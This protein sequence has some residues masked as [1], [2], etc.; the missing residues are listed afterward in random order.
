[1]RRALSR[2]WILPSVFGSYRSP[3]LILLASVI[4]LVVDYAAARARIV[5]MG[6]VG[7][8]LSNK[9]GLGKAYQYFTL[10]QVLGSPCMPKL[11][12]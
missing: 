4:I 3:R 6:G 10:N 5:D 12:Q 1:M 2:I 11:I 7:A 8:L 9:R